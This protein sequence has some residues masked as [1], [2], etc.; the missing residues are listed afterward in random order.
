M[1][2]REGRQSGFAGFLKF[3]GL[4]AIAGVL[5][6]ALLAPA[7]LI[8]GFAVTTGISVF[9]SLPDWIK[10]VNAS[11][12]STL[13]ATNDAGKPV[14]VATFYH[15]NRIS[16][17]YTD[18]S[19]NFVNAV[20]AT[21][22][23]RFWSH[24]GV[25]ILSLIRA[26]LASAASLG[27]G[28]GGSTITM[29]FVKNN[30]IEAAVLA[31]DQEAADKARYPSFDR[32]LKEIR[33]AISLEQRYSKQE[34]F[35][36][37]SN[38]SFF[39]G[40]INGIEAASNYY[41]GTSA[42]ELSIAQSAML[43]AM[44]KSPNDYRP[45]IA[46]NLDR[47]KNR[48]D[49][50][51]NNMKDAGYIT[52]SEA[53]AAKAEPITVKITHT[54]S[55]CEANQ[56]YAFFCDY[57]VWTIRNN[58][59]F[60]QTP[61]D[62][63]LLLRRGG[64]EIYTSM[65]LKMQKAADSAS[66]KWVPPSDASQIGTASVSVQV[67]TGRVL[68]MAENRVFD[69]TG[70]SELGHT[71]VNYATDRNY[72]GSSGFQTGSTY[73]LFTLGAWLNAGYKLNDHVDGRVRQW[74]ATDFRARCG[75][76]ATA[77]S[78]NN[79]TKEP[80]DLSVVQAT[81]LSVNTAFAAMAHQLDLCDIRDVA[82]SFGVHRADGNE[83]LYVPSSI[84]GINEIAPITMA[85]AL[86][87]ISNQGMFCTP[88]A[89]DRVVVRSTKTEMAIP[90]TKCSQA[91]TPEVSAGMLYAMK[92]VMAGGTGGASNT[93]D[94]VMLAGKT[95]TTDSG[96][97]TW[98]TGAS[99]AVATATWVGNVSGN[100]SLSR[101]SLNGKAGNTVRHDIWRTI[102]KVANKQ[103]PTS[104]FPNPPQSMID[105]TMIVVPAVGGAL[106]DNAR[107]TMQVAD[108]NAAIV[109]KKVASSQ[110]A[111]TVAYTRPSAGQV[112]PRGS[113]V[114]IFVSS[115]GKTKIPST[116]VVGE[117]PDVAIST[118]TALGFSAVAAPQPSQTQLFQHSDTIPEGR[119]IGTLPAVGSSAILTGAI[120]LIISS[121]P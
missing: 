113:Q 28:P 103:Y 11:Q 69:Q 31:G 37:Y 81:A 112:I 92:R 22:D 10:P 21:E 105:A 97:H 30:L 43:A 3:S 109:V 16:V 15:E 61:E 38:L 80:E 44:L 67:G 45:D 110:P 73:K 25:D 89:I 94:G 106:P 19:S 90:K 33:L 63:E 70:S 78:P 107:E 74:D 17:D 86:A 85:A 57:V 98:M 52:G 34:I 88:V 83:L 62:R 104:T 53:D 47:A 51:I 115:G 8:G 66:K 42:N 29:Q 6:M 108:L 75:N 5:F 35:A 24:A 102:M 59:E 118:L 39:G 111:G 26:S 20:V 23:P 93:G 18:I 54:P 101:I 7:L 87:G 64:L 120:L 49:Y 71:S 99:T 48:R 40:Q 56:T 121:G 119:V 65:N 79:I 1:S 72:G 91:V 96:V 117:T 13:Y 116:G 4:S 36:G 14:K 58:P 55:G 50:V 82:Q 41:F 114:K 32:K 100:K 27:N 76:V 2:R 77:W 84:L 9:E 95:G 46:E 12:S 68:A 60:G